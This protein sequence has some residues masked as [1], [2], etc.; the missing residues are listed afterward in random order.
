MI[1]FIFQ[2]LVMEF[3]TTDELFNDPLFKLISKRFELENQM[4]ETN[5][6]MILSNI[7]MQ[8]ILG[9]NEK[10]IGFSLND[11][12]AKFK[13]DHLSKTNQIPSVLYQFV[14]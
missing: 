14:N 8:H 1:T 10:S 12:E 4:Q 2:D 5:Q 3:E 7:R 9:V 6:Q 13:L 11:D